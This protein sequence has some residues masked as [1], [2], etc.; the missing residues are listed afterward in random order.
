[1]V[2]F[3]KSVMN[4]ATL[5][6]VSLTLFS[7]A[8]IFISLEADPIVLL[9]AGTIYLTAATLAFVVPKLSEK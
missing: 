5:F 9:I 3:N 2:F 1:M 4:G 8:F 6:G 7:L